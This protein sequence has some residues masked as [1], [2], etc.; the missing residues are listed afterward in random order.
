MS[1][2]AVKI[3]ATTADGHSF[4]RT[5]VRPAKSRMSKPVFASWAFGDL[6]LMTGYAPTSWAVHEVDPF[7]HEHSDDTLMWQGG[8]PD[9]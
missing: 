1:R 8:N 6:L 3:V 7:S 9:A 4:E 5:Y 2:Y